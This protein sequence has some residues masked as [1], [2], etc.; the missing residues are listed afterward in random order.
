[1]LV[2]TDDLGPAISE[3]TRKHAT[4][5]KD[6]IFPFLLS[7][8][9]NFPNLRSLYV[10]G[11]R[12]LV[13]ES[14]FPLVPRSAVRKLSIRYYLSSEE[15][16]MGEMEK[17]VRIGC[18][19]ELDINPLWYQHGPLLW[20]VVSALNE[21]PAEGCVEELTI[22]FHRFFRCVVE[23]LTDPMAEHRLGS[24]TVKRYFIFSND[25]LTESPWRFLCVP[26]LDTFCYDGC[27]HIVLQPD[28]IVF[29][30]QCLRDRLEIG[31]PPLRTIRLHC[32]CGNRAQENDAT[33]VMECMRE[34][35]S[36][37]SPTTSLSF[38]ATRGLPPLD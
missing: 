10:Y 23:S 17:L 30:E 34:I 5:V 7:N 25:G 11:F 6:F 13:R 16:L 8:P 22:A 27:E 38:S 35:R 36:R 19:R 2:A 20:R 15:T 4:D 24:L 21:Q 9:H 18:L 32:W 1:M 26:S 28:S 31:A 12:S 29:F 33:E 14:V 3:Q 37:L